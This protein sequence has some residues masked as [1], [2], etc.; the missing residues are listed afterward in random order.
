MRFIAICLLVLLGFA[1]SQEVASPIRQEE[2]VDNPFETEASEI[3]EFDTANPG[4]DSSS[5]E[6]EIP[7]P[8]EE[9]EDNLSET[10]ASD[11]T[12]FDPANPGGE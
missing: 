9:E 12:E 11:I 2:E 6:V 5:Q 7:I 10:E 8:K 4:G 1:S 3:T